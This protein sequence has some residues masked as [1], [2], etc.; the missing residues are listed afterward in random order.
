MFEDLGVQMNHHSTLISYLEKLVWVL[1][2]HFG[3]E[4]AQ[5][6]PAYLQNIAG[7]GRSSRKTPV[8]KA[9]II[10]GMVPCNVIADEILTD[11][12]D[13]YRAMLVESAN[14]VHSLAD[15]NRMREAL[16]SMELVVAI[17]I[18]MTE[19]AR[20]ADY[21]LPASTQFEKWEATFF[22]FEFPDNYFHLRKPLFEPLGESLSEAEIH[23]RFVEAAGAMPTA[24]VDELR[25]LLKED[26]RAAFR[27][28]FMQALAEDGMVAKLAPVILYRTLGEVLPE[29]A[30]EGAVMWPLTMGFAMRDSE[31]LAR[32]GYEGDPITQA[33]TLFD[34]IIAGHS[35]VVFSRD[36]M[37]TAWDRLGNEG[38]I[39]LVLPSLLA[40]LSVLE[41]GPVNRSNTEFPFALSAGER[42]DYT[43]NT[44]YRDFGWRRKDPDGSLRI[45]PEDAATIGIETGDQARITTLVGSALARVEVTDRMMPGHASIPN[46]FGLDN[47]DGTR[48]GVAPNELTSLGDC[49]KFAGTPHHKFVPARIEAVA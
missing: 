44:I 35:G 46:G 10:S 43:A 20:E 17:D 42:R 22:N 36:D 9:P 26:G 49:D 29:G 2:G 32:A 27:D 47:D 24:L 6:V 11:H 12:P 38:Q 33:E 31:S 39:Q 23:A 40:E 34:A 1:C 21:V 5:Y 19:T 18:A 30:K 37:Q 4:G 25:G 15:S 28:R 14:P 45:S 3:K 8:A 13:R 7:S 16:R 48:S 41:A